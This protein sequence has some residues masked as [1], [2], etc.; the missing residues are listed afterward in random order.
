MEIEYQLGRWK[1]ELELYVY[2]GFPWERIYYW[3]F[4]YIHNDIP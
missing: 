2:I 1:L 3:L 4:I